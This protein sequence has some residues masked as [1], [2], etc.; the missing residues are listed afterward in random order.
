MDICNLFIDINIH[1]IY[2]LFSFFSHNLIGKN[3]AGPKNLLLITKVIP[4]YVS[5]MTH[6]IM[7]AAV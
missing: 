6:C 1:T 5:G 7:H 2:T 3:E 4:G